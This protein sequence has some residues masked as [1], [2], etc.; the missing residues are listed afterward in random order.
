MDLFPDDIIPYAT[1]VVQSSTE[2][3]WQQ[4]LAA[5]VLRVSHD[6]DAFDQSGEPPAVTRVTVGGHDF[7]FQNN[8]WLEASAAFAV[9]DVS[10]LALTVHIELGHRVDSLANMLTV[11]LEEHPVSMHECYQGEPMKV[12]RHCTPSCV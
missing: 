3:Q 8:G 12:C 11:A 10:S 5:G 7:S 6:P 9:H 1:Q 4:L 2:S